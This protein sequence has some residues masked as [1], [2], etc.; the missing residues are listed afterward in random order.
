M[1]GRPATSPSGWVVSPPGPKPSGR[2][3]H[4]WRVD[5]DSPGRAENTS[6]DLLSPD[7][8]ER[9]AR[10]RSDVDRRRFV[11]ARRALRTIVAGAAGVA[12]ADIV[13]GVGAWGKPFLEE[14]APARHLEFN[15]THSADLGL[16]ALAWNRAVGIDVE[17][18]QPVKE[19]DDI[20]A[21]RFSAFERSAF[22]RMA[23]GD[24]L[25]AF[26]MLWVSKEAYLKGSGEGMSRSLDLFDVALH[27]DGTI[28]LLEVRDRP[29]DTARWTL[30]RLDAGDRFAAA[31][32]VAERHWPPR[33]W[34]WADA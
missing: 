26:F 28:E 18:I 13:F 30:T 12:P 31:L 7:E 4:V 21:A 32:A 3:V 1:E 22:E 5:L 16:V 17:R 6:I 33:L 34:Q 9:A 19:L 20:V 29:D 27:D 10:F 11:L 15:L 24:R 14:P 23:P 25:K 2:E 8:R